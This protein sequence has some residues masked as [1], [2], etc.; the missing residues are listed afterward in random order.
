VKL[1]NRDYTVIIAKTT[2][3]IGIAPPHFE[4]RWLDARAAIVT[5]AQTCEQF[6]PDGITIYMSSKDCLT[7]AFEQYKQVTS[8][9]IQKIFDANYPPQSLNLLDG[10]N[11]A[12]KDYFTR[13]ATGQAKPNG[14]AI[15][16]LI[17]GEPSDRSGVV[18]AIVQATKQIDTSEELRIGFVQVGDDFIARGFLNALDEDL[19]MHTEAKFDI[20][21]TQSLET[22]SPN[23]LTELLKDIIRS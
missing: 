11:L 8:D 7:G 21:Y 12:L 2:G 17:D 10:L 5:L 18:K 16:V 3:G 19:Q 14:A 4:Q 9:Q 23:S 1:E 6:D 22:I 13:K 20:V 15:I